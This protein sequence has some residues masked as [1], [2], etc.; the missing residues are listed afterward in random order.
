MVMAR[1]SHQRFEIGVGI[2]LARI[3][4]SQ[5]DLSA[6]QRSDSASRSNADGNIHYHWLEVKQI[7]GPKIDRAS[8]EIYSTSTTGNDRFNMG[9]T[10]GH[11]YVLYHEE[12]Q[13]HP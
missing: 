13:L 5:Y 11:I 6:V 10:L 7:E 9:V 12:V 4:R 1:S 3:Q 8:G 2:G